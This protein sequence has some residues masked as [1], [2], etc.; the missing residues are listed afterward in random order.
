[1]NREEVY[2]GYIDVK[3]FFFLGCV[4]S[5]LLTGQ[6]LWPGKAGDLDQIYL[7]RKTLGKFCP[8]IIIGKTLPAP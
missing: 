2:R 1:M 8:N 4:F 3:R 7:I 5:E 6:P